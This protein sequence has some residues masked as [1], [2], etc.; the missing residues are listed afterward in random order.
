MRLSQFPSACALLSLAL[1]AGCIGHMPPLRAGQVGTVSGRETAGLA[2]DVAQRKVLAEAAQ[3]TVDHGFRY[4][5]ILP[6]TPLVNPGM[7]ARPAPQDTVI[8]PG[9]DVRFR[10]LS[11]DQIGRGAAGVFDAYRLLNPP[12]KTGATNH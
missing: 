6:A 11:K 4:F 10:A 9:M 2:N 5:V 1:V 3:Q 7:A 12:N 8:R